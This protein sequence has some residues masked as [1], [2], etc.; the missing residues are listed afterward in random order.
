MLKVLGCFA[1]A[2]DLRLVGLAAAICALAAFTSIQ[3]LLHARRSE[4]ALRAAWLPVAAIAGGSGIWATHF[5]AMLAFSTGLP[6]G[7]A[8][9]LTA[10]SLICAIVL[11]GIGFAMAAFGGRIAASIGGAVVGGGIAAMHYTGMAAWEVP[12]HVI[13]DTRLVVASIAIGGIFGAGALWV[14][15]E[16]RTFPRQ[17]LAA[18][19]LILA[20]CGH[21][22]TAM[23]AVTISPDPTIVISASALPTSWLAI[24]VALAG[25]AILLLASAALGLDLRDRRRAALEGERLRSLANAAVEGLVVCAGDTIVSGNE[26]FAR[27]VG[28]GVDGLPGALLSQFLPSGTTQLALN[29]PADHPVETSLRRADGD[30][31]P[32]ELI[33]RTVQYASRAHHA[34]A[35]RDLSARRRAERQIQFLAHHDALTGLA[36][37]ASFGKRLEQE[38][39]T[40]TAEDRKLAALCL[41]LDRFKEVNDLFGHSAGDAMLVEVARLVTGVLDDTHMMARL[42]GDEFAVLAP[43]DSASAAGRLAEQIL[44]AMRARNADATGPLIASS[45]GIAIFPDDSPDPHLLMSHADTALYRAKGEG[46]GTY[47]FYEAKMGA[48][49]RDRR[50]LEHDLRHAAARGEFELVYQPQSQVETGEVVGFEAL[51]RW[52]HPQRGHVSPSVF[53]PIAEECGLILQIGE[54][55]LRETCREAASWPRPLGDRGERLGRTDPQPAFR[56]A[57]PRSPVRDGY[58]PQPAGDR[59]HRDG[60]DPRSRA[61]PA[62]PASAQGT[63]H[64]HRH[65]RFRHRIL[66]AVEPALVP[67]RQ[68]QDRRLL[69]ALRAQQRANGGDRPVGAG[70]GPGARHAR[71]RGRRRDR[72]GVALPATRILQ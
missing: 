51:L 49:V 6:S 62:D 64:P 53:I 60:A 30:E 61:C 47:R 32:V 41:D 48:E 5:I 26:A 56:P 65:G 42:G 54:W 44:D 12:G 72:G 39:R 71:P 28:V 21:H 19:L 66:I 8:L 59:D 18:L 35:V 20:I 10:V 45:I 15:R 3:L 50:V 69:R 29:A 27:L 17:L 7:Y 40:A 4:T 9:G 58:R 46:R 63:R 2:H 16:A 36:N 52:H 34:V 23:G 55:V 1:T 22:F 31:I 14:A 33:V 57:G 37:R 24:A 11:V 70:S 38:I 13:W 67:L 68:D 25:F 43:C